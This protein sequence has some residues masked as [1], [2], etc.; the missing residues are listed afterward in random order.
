MGE[1][2]ALGSAA[3]RESCS[4]V[5]AAINAIYIPLSEEPGLVRRFGEEYE[6][7]RDNVP[8]WIPRLDALGAGLV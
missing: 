4:S 8:R 6:E 7:Y 5:F 2:A 3:D 1:A